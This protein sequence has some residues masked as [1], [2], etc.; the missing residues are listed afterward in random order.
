MKV[1]V[2]I[3]ELVSLKD[4][5]MVAVVIL[6]KGDVAAILAEISGVVVVIIVLE[7][8]AVVKN[9]IMDVLKKTK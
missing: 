2:I 8:E 3:M 4:I 1:V 5:T 9:A 6:V 7:D